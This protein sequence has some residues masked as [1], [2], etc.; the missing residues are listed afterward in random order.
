MQATVGNTLNIQ[1]RALKNNVGVDDGSLLRQGDVITRS[2][3]LSCC[4]QDNTHDLG[5]RCRRNM[6]GMGKG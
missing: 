1:R 4:E 6:V 5:N 2:V 3:I